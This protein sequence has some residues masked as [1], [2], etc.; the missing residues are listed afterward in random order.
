MTRVAVLDDWQGVARESA[1]WSLLEAQ[2]E[3][4]F[5]D[6]PFAGEDGAAA[7]LAGFEVLILMRERTP[8]RPA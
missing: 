2:A 3:V 1:D 5:L 8:F 7:G 6:A 4:V